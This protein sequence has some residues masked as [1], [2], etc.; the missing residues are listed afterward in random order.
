MS[1]LNQSSIIM[2]V[3][4]VFG[5]FVPAAI[6]VGRY[7]VK[8]QR[9]S[10]LTSLR[11]TLNASTGEDAALIPSF[12]YALQKYDLDGKRPWHAP[13]LELLFYVVT[14]AIFAIIAVA[15]LTLL[16]TPAGEGQWNTV[17]AVLAGFGPQPAAGATGTLAAYQSLTATVI[18][19][20]FLGAYI[21]SIQYLIRRIANFDLSPM[22]FLRCSAQVILACAVA[23]VLRHFLPTP[24][25]DAS[26]SEALILL[27]AFVIG[28]FPNAGLELLKQ[29][30]PQLRLKR[31]DPDAADAYRL[32]P[33]ELIDGIDSQV[34]FRLAEREIADIQN[35]AT[36]NPILLS[37]ETPYPLLE[38]MD[39]IAQAQLA[40]EV[41]P[42][43]YR[44]LR[45]MGV[46]TI[47]GLARTEADGQLLA[48]VLK[49]LYE[50]E[51]DRPASLAGRLA[52]MR[53][54]LHV[55]RL[56]QVRAVVERALRVGVR[57]PDE[58]GREEPDPRAGLGGTAEMEGARL[59]VV[60]SGP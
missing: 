34:A 10:V 30:V 52:T 35:L 32:V 48:A 59:Q 7:A 23:A 53:A 42:K 13:V 36:E 8:H 11:Q 20:S 46:R 51:S 29:K 16:L 3:I 55:A 38:V 45:D 41:G 17:I 22:S 25:G 33:V 19:F 56:E 15:G 39:W 57:T 18:A 40:L 49:V 58:G 37:A 44:L 6:L 27:A 50:Q 60:S 24:E 5:L 26:W 14:T 28:F 54:S 21:W 47:D 1:L 9:Q 4:L 2:H 31:V 12:E 43:R